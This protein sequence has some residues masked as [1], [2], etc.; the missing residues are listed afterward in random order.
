[1]D[2]VLDQ[3]RRGRVTIGDEGAL[4]PAITGSARVETAYLQL[5]MKRLWDEEIAAGSQQLR[6]QTLRRLGGANTIVHGHLATSW[7]SCPPASATP[8]LRR[9]ASS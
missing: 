2:A 7:T 6:L 9:S 5:V 1:M 4:D 8:R 3:L